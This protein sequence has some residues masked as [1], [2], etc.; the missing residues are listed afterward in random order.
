VTLTVAGLTWSVGGHAILDRVDLTV[1]A[2][3]MVALIGP[4]GSGKSSI[5]RG[6]ARLQ[7]FDRGAVHLAGDDLAALPRRALGRTLALVEQQA[8]TDLDITVLDVVLLGRTPYRRP[9][10]GETDR[11]LELATAALRDVGM[12][13]LAD[14]SW[15]TL[16]GGERQRVHLARAIVQEPT[17]LLLDEP[18]NHLDAHHQLQLLSMVRTA[19]L[20][21]LAAIH[22]LNLAATY[23]D[24][25]VVLDH[26]R[27]HAAGT[28]AEVLTTDMLR[29]VFAV[30]ATITRHADGRPVVVLDGPVTDARRRPTLPG[31]MDSSP[32]PLPTPPARAREAASLTV[33][34]GGARSGK[35]AFAERW[36]HEHA[37]GGGAVAVLATAE[38]VDD[39][40]ADRI[41]RHRAL[42]PASWTTI[43][44]PLD[45]AGAIGLA[46]PEALLIVDCLTTW[47][48]NLTFHGVAAE[49]DVR[50]RAALAAIGA[51][52]GATVVVSNE[53]GLGIVPGDAMTREYRDALGRLNQSFV[54]AADQ[55]LLLVAGRALRLDPAT[56]SGSATE[57]RGG[58]SR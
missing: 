17:V 34:L 36:G 24:Q 45:L 26:G 52:S 25:L 44:E 29:E 37:A 56:P 42:R 23:F 41:A 18:T 51:R 39:E 55:A 13:D 54:A 30:D 4:N 46:P 31:S 57:P 21:T 1:P 15:H 53:V 2:G 38:I 28:V 33:L 47:L 10:Q 6:I 49:I 58:S 16:S 14:R 19:G 12:A 7:S 40:M 9:L 5:L 27:V 50:A 3:A 48:G 43:E 20:T 22:D 35:S 8:G 11:D 32:P